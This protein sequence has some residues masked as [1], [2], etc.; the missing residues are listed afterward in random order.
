MFNGAPCPMAPWEKGWGVAAR[1]IA[2]SLLCHGYVRELASA[3]VEEWS[4]ISQQGLANLLQ[5][6]KM[7]CTLELKADGGHTT[8]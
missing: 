2:S 6:M 5:S 3:L 4:N 7:R 1:R 8:N